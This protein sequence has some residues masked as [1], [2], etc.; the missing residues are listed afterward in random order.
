MCGTHSEG[1]RQDYKAVKKRYSVLPP[2]HTQLYSSRRPGGNLEFS[3]SWKFC[4]LCSLGKSIPLSPP[5]SFPSTAAFHTVY[6]PQPRHPRSV[7]TPPNSFPLA[8]P[9]V[10]R[11]HTRRRAFPGEKLKLLGLEKWDTGSRRA[12]PHYPVG[13]AVDRGMPEQGSLKL[14]N[15]GRTPGSQS[16]VI[17]IERKAE[18]IF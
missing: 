12:L 2:W 18:R 3:D 4:E 6:I 5:P 15:W 13:K 8:T 14:D 7:Y 9:W 10:Q 17:G 11:A 16:P 1:T